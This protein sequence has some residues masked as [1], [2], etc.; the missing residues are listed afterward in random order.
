MDKSEILTVEKER[1]EE[2]QWTETDLVR[3]R[4][5][6]ESFDER[7]GVVSLLTTNIRAKEPRITIKSPKETGSHHFARV[8]NLKPGEI[9]EDPEN[10]R[11]LIGIENLDKETDPAKR[12][13]MIARK[14]PAFIESFPYT[15]KV[16]I[17]IYVNQEDL[18]K[19]EPAAEVA[20]QTDFNNL[21]VT[22]NRSKLEHLYTT[23]GDN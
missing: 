16:P 18:R 21:R 17:K 9:L 5:L 20:P 15:Q 19:K 22:V 13:E 4:A 12:L 23:P 10:H 3:R 6:R 2:S 7:V 14:I 8:V 11:D 1:K